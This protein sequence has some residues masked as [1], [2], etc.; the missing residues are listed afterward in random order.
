MGVATVNGGGK[1]ISVTTL[2]TLCYHIIRHFNVVSEGFTA[3]T[4]KYVFS[5][6]KNISY[7]T[8]NTLRYRYRAKPVNTM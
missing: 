3:A 6:K 4:T 2:L 8:G 1:I 7:L 5:D